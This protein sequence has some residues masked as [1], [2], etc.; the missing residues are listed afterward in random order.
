MGRVAVRAG[1]ATVASAALCPHELDPRPFVRANVLAALA[2]NAARCA[3]GAL[4]RRLLAEDTDAVRAAAALAVST[5]HAS[6]EDARALER[7]ASTD[8][9]GAVSRRCRERQGRATVPSL[10]HTHAVDVYVVGDAPEAPKP[11]AAYAIEL[12]DGL[13]H[14]G[15]ADRRGAV[16]DPIVPEGDLSLRRPAPLT[17]PPAIA[18]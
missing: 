8:R 7:C 1:G 18:K 17:P 14:V 10:S 13:V 16:F 2:A 6:V 3:D 4:E 5:A 12:P 9:S 11:R 15:T